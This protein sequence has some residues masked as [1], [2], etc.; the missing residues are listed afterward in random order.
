[1]E[2]LSAHKVPS[3]GLPPFLLRLW[4]ALLSGSVLLWVSCLAFRHFGYGAPYSSP[5]PPKL[6]EDLTVYIETFKTFHTADFFTFSTHSRFAYPAASAVVYRFFYSFH[7]FKA[8]YAVIS[9]GWALVGIAAVSR[10]LLRRHVQPVVAVALAATCCATFPF[11]F[12]FQRGN[13]EIVLWMLTSIGTLAYVRRQPY[14]AAILWGMAAA[15]KIYPIFL[16]GVFLG[17]RRETGP[18]LTGIASALLTTLA[19]LWYVGPSVGLAFRGFLGGVQGF[20][21]A[22]AEFVRLNELGFDHSLFS[23]AKLLAI[24]TGHS[25]AAWLHPYYVIAGAVA[26]LVFLLRVRKLPFANRLVFLTVA[27]TLL[28]PV[29][30][31][32][33][34]VQIYVPG[35]LLLLY[36]LRPATLAT[37]DPPSGLS[38]R[39]LHSLHWA[40]ACIAVLLLPGNLFVLHGRLYAG[41][42]KVIPLLV[43][44]FLAVRHS[45][46]NDSTSDPEHLEQSFAAPRIS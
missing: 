13:I 17:R 4:I 39:S 43:L 23:V 24:G 44:A 40:L 6:L 14:A 34:L 22:Y 27:A 32:Y 29:S 3:S 31:E 12:L 7:R 36:A 35:I 5:F 45:W 21:G 10:A 1:M 8:A 42:V 26:A 28:P 19:S 33:T 38:D 46:S 2:K 20:Q 25:S 18:F 37:P 15:M 30:Y 11:V 16:L 41:Q 9:G